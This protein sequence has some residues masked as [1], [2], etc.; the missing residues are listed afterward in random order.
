MNTKPINALCV[1]HNSIMN[2]Y[3]RTCKQLEEYLTKNG[4]Q[5]S[6]VSRSSIGSKYFYNV[7]SN[8]PESEYSHTQHDSAMKKLLG[9]KNTGL[10]DFYKHDNMI[11][12]VVLIDE[13]ELNAKYLKQGNLVFQDKDCTDQQLKT[14]LNMMEAVDTSELSVLIQLADIR[15]YIYELLKE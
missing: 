2:I 1:S 8:I 9:I 13:K 14:I 10:V 7:E 4:F 3:H 15:S 11:H 12:Q 6:Y 5:V